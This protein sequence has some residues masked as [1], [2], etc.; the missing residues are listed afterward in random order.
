MFK[1]ICQ[2]ELSAKVEDVDGWIKLSVGFDSF[3]MTRDEA[4]S[5]MSRL[6]KAI[7]KTA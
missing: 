2:E 6:E 5:L 1:S 3:Y 4:L 7:H